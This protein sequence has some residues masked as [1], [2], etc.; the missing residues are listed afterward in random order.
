LMVFGSA[1]PTGSVDVWKRF[2]DVLQHGE[3]KVVEQGGHVVWLDDPELVAS[4]VQG[5]LRG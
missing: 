4:H 1:D 3:L 2:C 5:F